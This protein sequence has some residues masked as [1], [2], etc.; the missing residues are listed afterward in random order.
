VKIYGGVRFPYKNGV[1]I[2]GNGV[3]IYIEEALKCFLTITG[4]SVRRHSIFRI[5]KLSRYKERNVF[6]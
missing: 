1:K 5:I 4:V 6:R 3:K 2:Y